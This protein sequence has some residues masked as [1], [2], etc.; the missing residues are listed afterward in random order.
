MLVDT[1][2]HIYNEYY[3]DI[4]S[5]VNSAKKNDVLK[6]INCATNINNIDKVID[7]SHEHSFYYAIGIHPEDV[8]SFDENIKLKL[9]KY[10]ID[11]LD[12]PKFVAIGEIGLDCY[13]GKETKEKQT[14]LLEF[15][16]SLAEKYKKPVI[17]HSR[18]ATLDTIN[19]LKKH[20]VKGVIH[21][22]SGSYETA[23]EY[24]KMGYLIGIG[25]LVTFKNC[26]LKD[27]I[28]KIGIENIVLETDC[29]YMT[30]EPFRKY[31]NEPKYVLET[32]KFLSKI[33]D[34]SLEK[35]KEIT[36]K[37]CYKIFDIDK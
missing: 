31:R 1:H 36:T 3:E 17:I 33:F 8:G 2:A 16:M 29:P 10:I 25:G 32:A 24:I 27:Y 11:N 21:C 22:F 18:E 23:C 30:P 7:I 5:I 14:E 4:N 9:E 20:N 37:N 13:Y 35:L 34:I 28:T 15:Q 26:N 19:I 6:I 12:D